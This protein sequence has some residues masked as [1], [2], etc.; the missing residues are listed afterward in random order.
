MG[1]D[2]YLLGNFHPL[3]PVFGTVL[4]ASLKRRDSLSTAIGKERSGSYVDDPPLHR[5]PA[6]K[7]ALPPLGHWSAKRVN[8]CQ[9]DQH[10]H[11]Q[12]QIFHLELYFSLAVA[13]APVLG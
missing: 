2:I 7:L 13:A 3:S 9:R 10:R 8:Q 6:L 1:P 5:L 11:D 12:D 4:S